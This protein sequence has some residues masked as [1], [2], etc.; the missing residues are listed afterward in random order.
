VRESPAFWAAL[1]HPA[2]RYFILRGRVRRGRGALPRRCPARAAPERRQAR[3][4]KPGSLATSDF[5][6]EHPQLALFLPDHRRGVFLTPLFV[7]AGRKGREGESSRAASPGDAHPG[8]APTG[9]QGAG[10][11]PHPSS[12]P[13]T[14]AL[15]GQDWG[16]RRAWRSRHDGPDVHARSRRREGARLLTTARLRPEWDTCAL[17]HDGRSSLSLRPK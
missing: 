1:A 5:S 14:G 11:D 9:R 15:V 13:R 8:S 7:C 10:D 17:A 3:I 6:L 12:S 16:V 4:E 2:S